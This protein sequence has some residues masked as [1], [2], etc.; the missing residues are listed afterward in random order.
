MT[1]SGAVFSLRGPI[2]WCRPAIFRAKNGPTVTSAPIVSYSCQPN[3]PR[4]DQQQPLS[5]RDARPVANPARHLL[6]KQLGNWMRSPRNAMTLATGLAVLLRRPA[7]RRDLERWAVSTRRGPHAGWRCVAAVLALGLG[8]SGVGPC[9][10]TRE[11]AKTSASHACCAQAAVPGGAMP[12]TGT[13]VKTS[14]TPCCA[15]HTAG[16][17]AARLD[18]RDILRH[19]WVAAVATGTAPERHLAPSTVGASAAS[20]QYSS[21]PRS[22]VLRI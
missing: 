12:T 7:R 19:S 10:C 11:P 18:D 21:P 20:L 17:V 13:F 14:A 5:E 4:L 1:R 2:S 15:S 16:G 9:L 6:V 8:L 22:T 3:W